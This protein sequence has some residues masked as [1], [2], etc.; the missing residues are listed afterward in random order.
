MAEIV[1]TSRQF[2]DILKH[3]ATELNSKYSSSFPRNLGYNYGGGYSWDC[4]NLPK[5]LIWGWKEGGAV[6]SYTYAPGLYGLG[7]WDGGTILSHC[8]GVSTD[9]THVPA[10]E[11]LL[12]ENKGHAGI[13]VGEFKD[14]YGQLCNVVE[15]TTDWKT[16]RVIGSWVDADG[17]R[18][19]CKGGTKARPWHWHGMLSEWIDYAEI[20]PV[21]KVLTEDGAWG[22]QTT[23]WTQKLLGTLVDGVVSRQPSSNKKYLINATTGWEFKLFYWQYKYGSDMVRALQAFIGAEAD[24]WFGPMSVR[25][26]QTF[27]VNQGLYDGEIDGYMGPKTVV[28]WQKY[29]N[30]KFA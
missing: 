1:Y 12:T 25:A 23:V 21:Q 6:G 22:T 5:S 16:G 10:G 14:R 15:C 3:I 8:S 28:G 4:W 17:T 29:I 19:N 27:L 7:D 11:F 26:L 30:K 20:A 13:Y 2:C 9:F 18:R 24:G